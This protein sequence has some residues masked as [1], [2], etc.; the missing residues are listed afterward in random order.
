MY[1]KTYVEVNIDNLKNN[2]KNIVNYYNNYDYY[3]GVVKGNCYGH[4]TTYVINELI[5]SGIN[6]LAVSSLEEALEARQINK[7]IPILSLEPIRSEYIDICIK[8]NITITVHD[9]NYAQEIINKKIDKKL[10]IHLKVDSGMNRI[11]FK[12]KNELKEIYDKLKNKENIE[13]EGIFTHFATLGINDKEWDNQLENFKEITS[14]INLKEIPIV[15]LSKSASFINHPKIDF[16]NGIRLGIAMYGYDSTPKYSNRGIKNKLRALKRKINRIKENISNTTIELPIELK[17]AFKMFTE[18]MQVKKIKKG[19]FVGYGASYR[20]KEDEIIGILPVGYDDGIFRKSK[21]RVV[22]INNKNY[23]IIGDVGMGMSAIK[24]DNKVKMY[25]KVTLIGDNINIKD[26]ARHNETSVYEIM[27][28]IGKQIPRVYI[29]NNEVF[30]T[31]EG[32]WEDV[33]GR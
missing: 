33:Y 22:S 9:Y 6:Y 29:K 17:P 13:I 10:K 11:G 15:H 7:K 1:R 19:E 31:E 26:V 14:E 2:V 23:Q 21:G 30:T 18:V 28:N 5:E 3:F 12:D 20:A 24:I 27:C 4:G 8:N 16:S 32:K 25:D